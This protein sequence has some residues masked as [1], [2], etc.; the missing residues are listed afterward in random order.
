MLCDG[1]CYL[2][3]G[4]FLEGVGANHAAGDLTGNGNEGYAI[5][6]GVGQ[7]AHEVGG[8][9]TG[10]SDAD[11]G[12]AGGSRVALSGEHTAL[13]VAREHVAD[14]GGTR[15]RLVD[16]HRRSTRVRE[17]ILDALALKRLHEDVGA[18]AG[19][20]EAEARCE[21]FGGGGFGGGGGIGDSAGEF[22]RTTLGV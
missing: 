6:E 10:G 20:L 15:E 11:A 7:A 2:N 3:D 19:L 1:T 5:E 9:G 8:A 16:L 22:E 12:E 18:L 14:G 13:L 21:G 4:G 17:N